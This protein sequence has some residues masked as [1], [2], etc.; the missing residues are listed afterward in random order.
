MTETTTTR[1]F[2]G[3][4]ELRQAVGTVLG[5]SEWH[6]VTQEDVDLFATAT[7]DHQWIHTD[8]ARAAK[9]PFGGTIAHGYLT[10]ALVPHLVNNVYSVNNVSM[11]VNYGSNAVRFPA[12]LRVFDRVR[13]TVELKSVDNTAAGYKTVIGVTIE[14][15]GGSK[16]VCVAEIITLVIE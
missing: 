16:P 12:P 5:T 7:R 8:V 13:A 9:G 6:Q 14:A 1:T 10:L 4:Q 15:G 2:N 3:I 11:Q